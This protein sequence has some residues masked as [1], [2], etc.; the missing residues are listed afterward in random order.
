MTGA[1]IEFFFDFSSPYGYLASTQIDALAARHGRT[2][3]WRPMMLGAAF[4]ETGSRPLLQVPLKGPY[5]LRDV[6]RMARLFGVPYTEPDLSTFPL[7]A[8]AAA[9][10]CLW[11]EDADPALAKRLAQAILRRYW[12]E[13]QD[14]AR[15][16]QVAELAAPLG[17]DQAALLA[18]VNDPAIK[19]RLKEQTDAAVARG[20]FGSPFFF[21]DGE[22]FWGADR[23]DQVERWLAQGGW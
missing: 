11:L 22:P 21:V 10:A 12:G 8:L 2:V 6:P 14:V 20:V 18:A 19:Q 16:E 7:R 4:K 17:V 15:P 1:A 3:A 5:L 9:R 13:G 23:L